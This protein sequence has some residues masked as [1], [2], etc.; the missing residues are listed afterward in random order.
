MKKLIALLMIISFIYAGNA[1]ALFDTSNWGVR[2]LGMGAAFTAVADD[3]SGPLYNI[4]GI[5]V[6]EKPEVTFMSARLAVVSDGY[7]LGTDYLAF[8]YPISEKWGSV[9]AAWSYFGDPGLRREDT[10]NLG[11]ARTLNDLEI[12]DEMDLSVGI[13]GK[14]VRQEVD[15]GESASGG[16]KES[17]GGLTFDIGVLARFSYGISFGF[18]SKYITRPDVGYFM[19]DK[20]PS[21]NV[22]GFAYYTE[23]VP[24][25]KIPEFT[26]AADYEMRT[27]DENM[28]KIG[29]ETRLIDG[30]LALRAG[31]WSEQINF[32]IGYGLDIAGS[33]VSIDYA[34][35]LP[36]EMQETMGSHFLSLSF[37][38]P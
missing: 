29:A 22:I 1:H 31:G 12:W 7:D 30:S 13:N 6:M 8:V 35:G 5:A 3:A 33:K 26:I 2:P 21:M 16:G 28:M 25:L 10:I 38:F 15:F 18:S 34:F 24:I 27:G 37:R 36:L 9:S 17:K 4:A 20:V 32:G 23:K 19:E 11:Y 14:Y